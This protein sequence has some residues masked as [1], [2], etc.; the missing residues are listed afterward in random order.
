MAPI[1]ARAVDEIGRKAFGAYPVEDG[2]LHRALA[3]AWT[4]SKSSE[5]DRVLLVLSRARAEKWPWREVFTAVLN[6]SV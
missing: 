5:R 6:G 2:R 4:T 3:E 1:E